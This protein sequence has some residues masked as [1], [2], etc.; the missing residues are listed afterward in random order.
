MSE[1]HGKTVKILKRIVSYEAEMFLMPF[2]AAGP[3]EL[4]FSVIDFYTQYISI[5]LRDLHLEPV[6]CKMQQ[7]K[8]LTSYS[9]VE[10]GTSE[11]FDCIK[12]TLD[13]QGNHLDSC[14]QFGII[15]SPS[16][17]S[18]SANQ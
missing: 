14:N 1:K 4:R 12:L 3:F 15:Q 10:Q 11:D 5:V 18:Y 6:C 17:V 16:E 13:D 9:F 2:Y 8:F 7:K